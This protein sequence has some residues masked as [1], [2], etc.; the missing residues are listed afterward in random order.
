M[1]YRYS[2]YE[3]SAHKIKEVDSKSVYCPYEN[4]KGNHRKSSVVLEVFQEVLPCCAPPLVQRCRSFLTFG[5][6]APHNRSLLYETENQLIYKNN[7][8]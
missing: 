6:G 3:I 2:W 7:F 8:T 5:A 4:S 1:K